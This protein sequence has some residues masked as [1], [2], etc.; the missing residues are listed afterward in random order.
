MAD[1]NRNSDKPK[2]RL[3]TREEITLALALYMVTP[4]GKISSNNK[5]IQDL[6]ARLNRSSGS[7]S[8]KLANLAAV[9]PAVAASGRKG[10][11]NGGKLDREVWEDYV[12]LGNADLARLNSDAFRTAHELE[13]GVP[14]WLGLTAEQQA[15]E[16]PTTTTDIIEMVKRRR[17]QAFFRRA[18]LAKMENRCAVTGCSISSIL[19][20]A[21]IVPW[22]DDS[23]SRLD[24]RNGIAL[25]CGFHAAFDHHLMGIRPDGVIVI[26]DAWVKQCGGERERR[27]LDS[28]RDA[29]VTANLG[30]T[31]RVT[32]DL[33]TQRWEMFLEQERKRA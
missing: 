12:G 32:E 21:H 17:G 23:T 4:Y 31:F 19:D 15:L 10:F 24:P 2:A 29:Q 9:D 20:A 26:S 18:I 13:I 33:L 22:S 16:V 8:L 3:W 5:A 27:Y 25:T 28:L 6:A 7:V 14:E 30:R 1:N 11:S